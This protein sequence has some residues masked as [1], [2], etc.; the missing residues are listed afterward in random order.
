VKYKREEIIKKDSRFITRLQASCCL[1]PSPKKLLP[2]VSS[3]YITHPLQQLHQS[4][5][6]RQET[7]AL[8]SCFL[9][10]RQLRLF[11]HI[12]RAQ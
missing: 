9:A 11:L 1:K 4:S 2:Q 6:I 3:Y 10:W 8:I 12:Y 7:E 5:E